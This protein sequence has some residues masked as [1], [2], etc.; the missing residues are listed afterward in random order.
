MT[1][2]KE[3]EE[4]ENLERKTER[5]MHWVRLDRVREILTTLLENERKRVFQEFL[6][7]YEIGDSEAVIPLSKVKQ[8]IKP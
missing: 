6:D 1:K 4:V 8:I 7:L 3:V 5:G 2:I